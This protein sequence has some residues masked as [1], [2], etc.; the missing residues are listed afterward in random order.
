M[1][2][3][4]QPLGAPLCG[5]R[6]GRGG[7][8]PEGGDRCFGLPRGSEVKNLLPAVWETQEVPSLGQEDSPEEEMATHSTTLAWKIPGTEEPDWRQ[9]MGVAKSRTRLGD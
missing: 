2:S 9:S 1:T 5:D 3:L 6:E 8:V 4:R 7:G